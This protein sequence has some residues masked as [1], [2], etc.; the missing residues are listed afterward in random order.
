MADQTK[1]KGKYKKWAGA[2][3]KPSGKTKVKAKAKSK[4]KTKKHERP[5]WMRDSAKK[6]RKVMEDRHG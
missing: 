2:E 3:K 5:K 4:A 1:A 6:L